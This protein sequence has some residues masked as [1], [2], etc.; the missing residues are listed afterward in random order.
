MERRH[1]DAAVAPLDN[2]LTG[3]GV[4]QP[5]HP[6]FPNSEP[7]LVGVATVSTVV[8]SNQWW[9]ARRS[10]ALGI[11]S[12]RSCHF[13]TPAQTKHGAWQVVIE[14]VAGLSSTEHSLA[15][16]SALKA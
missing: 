1:C 10:E 13:L 16:S 12:G 11:T 9:A 14:F 4:L 5:G 6:A 15:V 7:R 3:T 8:A 2:V